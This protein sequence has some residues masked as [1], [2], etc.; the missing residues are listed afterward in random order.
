MKQKV[1]A[2]FLALLV[3]AY[4]FIPAMNA[5][6]QSAN[7]LK[8]IAVTGT[9]EGGG[10]FAG[11]FSVERFAEDK[12]Q[13]V[14]IGRLNGTVKGAPG[15]DKEVKNHPARMPVKATSEASNATSSQAAASDQQACPILRLQLGPLDLNL[16]GLRV[17][18]NAIDLRI[19]AEPGQGNLLGNLLCS[20]ANLLNPGGG[21]LGQIVNLL[22]Q[23]LAKLG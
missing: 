21:A 6:A 3:G 2:A 12:G 13:I 7:P 22:N 18:L 10:S 4:L 15:G 9:G 17:Q 23:I 5:A 8:N 16:L 14:A 11:T 19:G 1:T 20:I